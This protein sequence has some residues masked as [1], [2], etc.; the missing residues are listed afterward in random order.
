MQLINLLAC[1]FYGSQNF[2]S[3]KFTVTLVSYIFAS[4]KFTGEN[5]FKSFKRCSPIIIIMI[6]NQQI[7]FLY[8]NFIGLLQCNKISSVIN[9]MDW[10]R[11]IRRR[12]PP[13]YFELGPASQDP[14]S[15]CQIQLAL[16]TVQSSQFYTLVK[17]S[18]C[19]VSLVS[20][21]ACRSPREK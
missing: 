18:Q 11:T 9:S 1:I 21:Q 4:L 12:K 20:G 15:F 16:P 14:F 3:S 5:L 2:L 7:N 10:E 6:F 19:A 13:Q 8:L 17:P